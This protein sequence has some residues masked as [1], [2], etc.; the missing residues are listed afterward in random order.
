MVQTRHPKSNNNPHDHDEDDDVVGDEAKHRRRTTGPGTVLRFATIADLYG[1]ETVSTVLAGGYYDAD[2][3]IEP[4]SALRSQVYG[5]L[6]FRKDAAT[7]TTT[8]SVFTPYKRLPPPIP[9]SCGL[10]IVPN[11]VKDLGCCLPCSDE[12]RRNEGVG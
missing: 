4:P 5:H 11:F 1:A 8:L 6:I 12:T 7:Q 10:V 2:G 3:Y 9:P